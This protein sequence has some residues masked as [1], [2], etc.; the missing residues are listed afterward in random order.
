LALKTIIEELNNFRGKCGGLMNYATICEQLSITRIFCARLIRTL[1][2][3][4][5]PLVYVQVVIIA[6]Y[7]YFAIAIFS[8]QVTDEDHEHSFIEFLN[9]IPIHGCLQFIFYM[10]W[11]KVAETMIN[12][13]GEDD[14]DFEVNNMIDRNLQMSYL[15]V[16]EMHQDHPELLKDQY[17]NEIPSELPDRVKDSGREPDKPVT[18][19]FDVAMSESVMLRQRKSTFI[20][21]PEED[22]VSLSIAESR[23]DLKPR[24]SVIDDTYRKISNVEVSQNVLE[25]QM[26]KT[27]EKNTAFKLSDSSSDSETGVK[28]TLSENSSDEKVKPS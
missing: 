7:S 20:H 22:F 28:T 19:V 9:Y 12:P 16:D 27:R 3:I 6:T 5:I 11:L 21:P 10:G 26:Q 4:G 8:N 25:K 1:T 23:A 18:D 14:D 17:W 15:I 13:F 24:S 2:P